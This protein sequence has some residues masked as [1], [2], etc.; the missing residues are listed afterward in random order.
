MVKTE[1]EEEEEIPP[2]PVPGDRAKE[3]GGSEAS[4]IGAWFAHSRLVASIENLTVC[5]C[6]ARPTT[7]MRLRARRSGPL[8]AS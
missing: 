8:P 1:E 3:T 2:A 7:P 4:W 5:S 6:S